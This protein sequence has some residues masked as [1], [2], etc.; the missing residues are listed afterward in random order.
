MVFALRTR[1]CEFD[2][3]RFIPWVASGDVD[4]TPVIACSGFFSSRFGGAGTGTVFQD[5]V[6]YPQRSFQILFR[7]GASGGLATSPLVGTLDFFNA[8]P[9]GQLWQWEHQRVRDSSG[10]FL[11]TP[12]PQPQGVL[13]RRYTFTI[14][15][16]GIPNVDGATPVACLPVDLDAGL[17]PLNTRRYRLS[18]SKPVPG[19]ADL[20][21]DAVYVIERTVA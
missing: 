9:F 8:P 15:A 14:P 11:P 2:T 4:I 12:E 19:G 3:G 6:A 10:E 1:N 18:F 7:V 20:L 17:S 16:A 21:L 5:G 13:L